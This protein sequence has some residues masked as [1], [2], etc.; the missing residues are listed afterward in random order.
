[1]TPNPVTHRSDG[2]T[3]IH[4][5]YKAVPYDCI[6]DTV[7]YSKV[8]GYRWNVKPDIKKSGQ[9]TWY[10]YTGQRH[11]TMHQILIGKGGDHVNHNGLDNRQ[12]NLRHSN[13]RQN[14]CNRRKKIGDYTSKYKGVSFRSDSNKWRA[15]VDNHYFGDWSTETE[16]A[17]AYNAAAKV[18]HGEFAVLNKIGG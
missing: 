7:D 4:I 6:I 3:A 10:A 16:A 8:V 12:E 13:S 2:T 9:I 11:R 14:A 1:M 18:R 5:L 15:K 17:I